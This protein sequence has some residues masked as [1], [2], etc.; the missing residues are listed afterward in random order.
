MIDLTRNWVFLHPSK[1]GGSSVEVALM[2]S[3]LNTGSE[4]E[5]VFGPLF[6]VWGPDGKQHWSYE[7][8]VCHFHF[9]AHWKK[10][11]TVR[12][13]YTRVLSEFR[14]QLSGNRR[15]DGNQECY[16]SA[17]INAAIKSKTLW[18]CAWPWH[19]MSQFAYLSD[20]VELIR[21]EN[22]TEDFKKVTG[23]DNLKHV[24]KSPEV[25]LD[26]L[27]DESKSIIQ[28]KF[29]LDFLKLNYDP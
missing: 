17:D 24:L 19:G 21:F 28:K 26:E 2:E 4:V 5:S 16:A 9:T 12:H 3:A 7:K 11:A 8:M 18:R 13:P 14:Y 22:L 1:T 15:K 25:E 29:P 20:D 27:D 10:F 6:A 23:L